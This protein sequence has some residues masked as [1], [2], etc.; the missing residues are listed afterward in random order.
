[1]SSQLD[2]CTRKRTFH[3]IELYWIFRKVE[4]GKPIP[5]Y[6]IY[7]PTGYG[8]KSKAHAERI[9]REIEERENKAGQDE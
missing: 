2:L 3:G 5:Y 1:M 8:F 9:A 4:G 6:D 7:S